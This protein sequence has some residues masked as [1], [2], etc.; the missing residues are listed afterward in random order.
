[1]LVLIV[2]ALCSRATS[3]YWFCQVPSL[4]M[5]SSSTPKL[6]SVS[7][8]RKVSASKADM[9]PLTCRSCILKLRCRRISRREVRIST[10]VLAKAMRAITG[11]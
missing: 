11:S 8:F 6:F 4:A 7:I 9:P 3:R 5:V 1:M 10:G 2:K